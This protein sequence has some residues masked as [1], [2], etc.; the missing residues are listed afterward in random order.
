MGSYRKPYMVLI[1]ASRFG[2]LCSVT[3]DRSEGC[4]RFADTGPQ[5]IRRVSGILTFR[6]CCC[7]ASD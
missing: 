4:V 5:K 7:R 1:E 2:V 6:V 3:S